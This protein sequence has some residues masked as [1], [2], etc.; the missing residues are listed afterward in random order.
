MTSHV[1]PSLL[2]NIVRINNVLGAGG[3]EGNPNTFSR[4][5]SGGA[6]G[7]APNRGNATV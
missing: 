6:F 2:E 7:L 1:L 4:P 5:S 3:V